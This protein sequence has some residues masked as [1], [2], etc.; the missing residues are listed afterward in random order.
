MASDL[1]M[2][3]WDLNTVLGNKKVELFDSAGEPTAEENVHMASCESLSTSVVHHTLE[4]GTQTAANLKGHTDDLD[5]I[6]FSIK[7]ASQLVKEI[8]KTA[9]DKCINDVPV[10]NVCGVIAIIVVKI[11][12]PNNKDIR[13]IPGLGPPARS[14]RLLYLRNPDQRGTAHTQKS[15]TVCIIN[16]KR[17]ELMCLVEENI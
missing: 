3:I 17:P 12:N 4:I 9:T 8:G 11:V 10:S 5:T 1:P 13:D 2:S 7:K 6:Q 15:K 16:T 14:R